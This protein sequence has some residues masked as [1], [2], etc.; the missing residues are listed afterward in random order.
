MTT[1]HNIEEL[2]NCVKKNEEES[3]IEINIFFF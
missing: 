1:I 2:K 3:V